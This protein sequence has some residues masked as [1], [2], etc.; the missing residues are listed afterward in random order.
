M[1]SVRNR[2][3]EKPWLPELGVRGRILHPIFHWLAKARQAAR[4]LFITI[5][6]L[7]LSHG[8]L[9]AQQITT[10]ALPGRTPP[11]VP[12]AEGARVFP[13][14]PDAAYPDAAPVLAPESDQS[15][16]IEAD[17]QSMHGGV[18]TLDG[19]V[20]ITSKDRR[21]QADHI[22]YDSNTG[23][24]IATGHLLVLGGAND[25]RITASHGNF[26]LRTATGSFYDVSGSVGLHASP[27]ARPT[28]YR[29]D[30]PFLFTGRM[31]VK[32][33]PRSYDVFDG[34]VT[35]CL[36][37]TPDW[38]LSAGRFSVTEQKATARNSTFRL[39]NLP[40]LFLPY[41]THPIDQEA[42]QSGFLIP[43]AGYS[44]TR[45]FS[46]G[47]EIYF[48]INRST[49]L[50]VG[51]EYYSLRGFSQLA[52]FRYRGANLDFVT[53]HYTGLLDRL[54]E[55]QNQGG[56]DLTFAGRHD[57]SPRTR[58][59]ANV[60]YLSSY[61]YREAFSDNFNQAVTSDIVSTAYATHHRNGIELGALAD[62]YQGIKFVGFGSNPQQQVRIFH[63]PTLSL[64][65]TEHRLRG[66]GLQLSLEASA[67][68][69]KRSQPNFA[70]G[71]I[72]ERFDLHP[73]AAYPFSLGAWRVRPAVAVRE[74]LYTRSAAPLRAGQTPVESSAGLS[75][76]DFE[77]A[78]DLRAP[79]LTRTFRPTVLPAILG[80]ELRH[81]I[82]PELTYRLATGVSN[83]AQVLRFD[84]TD[85]ASD[86]HEVEYGVTQRLFR[87][88]SDGAPCSNVTSFLSGL[89]P[90]PRSES[91]NPA[92]FV[93]GLNPDPRSDSSVSGHIPGS[94]CNEGEVFSWRL[95][96]KYFFDPT[97]GG[98][99]RRRRRNIFETTLDFSGTAFL[100]EP[101]EISPLISRLRLRSSAHTDVEWD[102]DF[103][104]GAKHF[105]SSNVFVDVH[106]GNAFTAISYA[107]LDAP[108]RSFSQQVTPT[109][110]IGFNSLVSDFNQL[111]F[112]LGYGSP[113]KP[114]LSLASNLG[115]DLKSF[116]G[117]ANAT[118]T[119]GTTP[120][121]ATTFYPSLFQYTA[122]QAAYNWN[123]CGVA[124][125]YSR[126]Q[127]GSVR[128]DP[129][130]RFSFSLANVASFGNL[131]RTERLF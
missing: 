34:T 89:N 5:M 68:G 92:S 19:G 46:V 20:L 30:N 38:L 66:T 52:T 78:L 53:A 47:D 44:S 107:R 115:L 126:F 29:N 58:V 122:V 15:P 80:S 125:K 87:K 95:A 67:S 3:G 74:T 85:V 28:L 96:Q 100:T 14:A 33:G 42:R 129:G 41:V 55:E 94:V 109:S 51:A 39:L 9:R 73:E 112:L 63:V 88:T 82:E 62:R 104:T 111:R 120:S 4:S 18:Y 121:V 7:P 106:Q 24:V 101:R 84:V 50:L 116:S 32:K 83:F 45:G 77:F 23:E 2:E 72:V 59:A 25:E 16:I 108:G 35:S 119:N 57:F 71:G 31:V 105:T 130:F 48:A 127:L 6:L 21:V 12:N 65:S 10:Q 90:D 56:E 128:N 91:S 26:N 13:N 60:E 99:V 114:G 11:E 64:A 117:T 102:F 70:T 123:C 27:T 81:T 131:R 37:P 49:D 97:F 43:S 118:S 1:P 79:V 76:S 8:P 69:L 36:L 75:R 86:T 17:I 113:A 61:I 98:A 22:E 93:S 103:D 124:F 110:T 54:P 40:I